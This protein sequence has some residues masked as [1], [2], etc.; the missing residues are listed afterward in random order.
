M[1]RLELKN[2][3][4]NVNIIHIKAKPQNYPEAKTFWPFTYVT[5]IWWPSACW[6]C[7]KYLAFR[8]EHDIYFLSSPSCLHHLC[9]LWVFVTDSLECLY[10]EWFFSTDKQQW[11]ESECVGE[12]APIIA[13]EQSGWHD[14]ASR[15]LCFI[16]SLFPL[17]LLQTIV[18]YMKTEP[19]HK[20]TEYYGHLDY[21]CWKEGLGFYIIYLLR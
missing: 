3:R 6:H 9:D 21:K 4:E 12:E 10:W 19:F 8:E 14:A 16:H 15:Y 7:A 1:C 20:K 17:C 18:P 13:F 5:A 11:T 2:Y